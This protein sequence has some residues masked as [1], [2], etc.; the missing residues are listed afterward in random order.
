L[1]STRITIAR[2]SFRKRLSRVPSVHQHLAAGA[3]YETLQTRSP[4]MLHRVLLPSITNICEQAT[5]T[6]T[7]TTADDVSPRKRRK[8][9]TTSMLSSAATDER[10]PPL[11]LDDFE[12]SYAKNVLGLDYGESEEAL[13]E[14]L[15]IL[16]GEL[17]CTPRRCDC[18]PKAHMHLLPKHSPRPMS[19]G[20][21]SL[22][23]REPRVQLA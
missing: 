15:S 3:S 12:A 1:R 20:V 4:Q 9:A 11:P 8:T 23:A 16:A 6:T 13:D 18:R 2:S 14:K 21:Q 22:L 17:V 10:P 7:T 5:S 19:S